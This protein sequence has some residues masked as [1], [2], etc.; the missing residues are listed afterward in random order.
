MSRYFQY[1]P[2]ALAGEIVGERWT[3]LV[4]RELVLGA[5]RF[6][7]IHRGMPRMSPALLTRRLRTLEAAGIVERRASLAGIEYVL[8][9]AG[10]ELAPVVEGLAV[11]GKTWLPATLKV[12]EM[13]P[14]LIVWDLHRRLD[15]ER[16]PAHRVVMRFDFVDQPKAKRNRWIVRDEG[17]VGMCVTDPG[18]EVDLFIETDT[19]TITLVWYGDIP[20]KKAIDDGSIQLDGPRQLCDTFPSWLLLNYMA[21]VPRRYPI[22]GRAA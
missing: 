17:G 19:R 12:T 7:D 15:L 1:C 5:T 3:L 8:T 6:N 4:L 21:D 20:L 16:M 2:L 18:F 13:D 22:A 14:D 10:A 9:D 11:W